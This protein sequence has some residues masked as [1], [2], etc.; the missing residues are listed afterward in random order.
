MEPT[1]KYLF[2]L[3]IHVGF[4]YLE[5]MNDHDKYHLLFELDR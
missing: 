5:H 3:V 1:R 4:L 2:Y